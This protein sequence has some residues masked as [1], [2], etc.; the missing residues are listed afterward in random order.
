MDE[1]FLNDLVLVFF[2]KSWLQSVIYQFKLAKPLLDKN[3]L[4]ISVL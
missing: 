1:H 4:F 3:I 2:I